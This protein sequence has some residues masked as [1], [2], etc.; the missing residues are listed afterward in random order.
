MSSAKPFGQ[1]PRAPK[2]FGV[3][4]LLTEKAKVYYDNVFSLK[5]VGRVSDLIAARLRE[6]G[7]DELKLRA[8]LLYGVFEAY[9]AQNTATSANPGQVSVECGIDEEKI[10]IGV[11]FSIPEGQEFD[12]TGVLE[13]VNAKTPTGSFEELLV[14][15][16]DHANQ[17]VLRFQK[18]QKRIEVVSLVGIPGKIAAET[19]AASSDFQLIL[20]EEASND[21]VSTEAYIQLA[22]LDYIALLQEDSPAA[23]VK[24]PSSGEILAQSTAGAVEPESSELVKGQKDEAETSQ[25]VQG[26]ALENEASQLVKGQ[27]DPFDDFEKALSGTPAEEETSELVKGQKAK[28]DTFEKVVKGSQASKETSSAVKGSVAAEGDES[29][30]VIGGSE[31]EDETLSLVKGANS[32]STK[33]SSLVKG[34]KGS[35]TAAGS[36]FIE[37]DFMGEEDSATLIKGG[38]ASESALNAKFSADGSPEEAAS[39]T[40]KG[41]SGSL[42]VAELK[43]KLYQDKITEL[44]AKIAAFEEER[45]NFQQIISERPPGSTGAA[46][47]KGSTSG[48]PGTGTATNEDGSPV[49]ESS[50]KKKK[51]GFFGG[52]FSAKKDEGEA[53]EELDTEDPTAA[54]KEIVDIELDASVLAERSPQPY[55]RIKIDAGA[56]TDDILD[57]TAAAAPGAAPPHL[58][59][60][61]SSNHAGT[62]AQQAAAAAA[63]EGAAPAFA[64]DEPTLTPEQTPTPVT[65][66]VAKLQKQPDVSSTQMATIVGEMQTG[67][68][69]KTLDRVQAE[70]EDIKKEIPS[71]R[72]KRWVDGLMQEVIQEKAQLNELAKNLNASL[73][74]KENEFKTKEQML[75]GELRRRDEMIKQKNYTVTKSKEQLGQLH[76]TIEKMRLAGG[77]NEDPHSKQKF[78]HVQKLLAVSKEE[79]LKL[80]GSVEDLKTQLITAQNKRPTVD[81]ATQIKMD[82]SL[83]QAEEFKKVNQQLLE[84]IN[85]MKAKS[86]E[87]EVADIKKKLETQLKLV[88]ASKK[89]SERLTSK[90]EDMQ[91]EELRLKTELGKTLA[92]N[93]RLKTT[94]ARADKEAAA[95]APVPAAKPSGRGNPPKAA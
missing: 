78:S 77:T 33:D 74:T 89:E 12:E 85:E 92:E 69:T 59:Q 10:A 39:S 29:L 47:G 16:L 20:I 32:L 64:V 72:A 43:V 17:V 28:A 66:I 37:G 24:A 36:E 38:A 79:N 80:M 30:S 55:R 45:A 35:S 58:K 67:L 40:S 82:R 52:M 88:V 56:S 50:A 34:K 57:G 75:M 21:A 93:R 65:E 95:T 22:D 15:L 14:Y 44:Q 4:G 86:S 54:K 26:S 87:A 9:S 18:S 2:T 5:N 83:K 7:P 23:L 3:A 42:A 68:L 73:R 76:T 62:P 71:E 51:K 41:G 84:R 60:G 91:K 1:F 53:V 49:S 48:A 46:Y 90:V 25:V 70:I 13:R 63:V 61:L 19:L 11:S 31:S 81:P 8:L 94:K 6:F 27:K